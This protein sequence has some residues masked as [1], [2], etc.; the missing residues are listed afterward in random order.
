MLNI[1][2]GMVRVKFAAILIGPAG[3]GLLGIYN[4]II[5]LIATATG[6]GIGN[7]GVRQVAE[8]VGSNDDERIARTVITLRRTA[9]LTGAL[10]M[11]VMII[12]CVP[13]SRVTFG[14][15]NYAIS[16]ALLGVTLLFSA[17]T[18][19][20]ACLLRG[21]RRIADIARITVISAFGGTLIS[22]PCFYL[23]GIR[24]IV[25]SQIL[26]SIA[27]LAT[28]WWYAR[29]FQTVPLMVSWPESR[30]EARSLLSLGISFMGAALATS[31]TAYA[32]QALLVRHFSLADAGIYQA[33]YNLS[34]VLVG[35]VLGAMGADYYPR[36][37]AIAG[38]HS[39][40]HRMV[41]E[42]SQV[43][44]LLALPA[45]AAMMVFAPLI[46]QFFYSASF[47]A[48][49]PLLRWCILGILGRVFSWPIGFVM[50]A[51]GKGTIYFAT[52]AF[53]CGLHLAAVALFTR[54]WGLD[55]AGIAFMALY[56]FYTGLML[57]VMRRLVGET[58]TR[59]T[60]KLIL[61][62]TTI[63]LLLIINCRLNSNLIGAWSINIC[64]LSMVAYYCLNQ[65]LSKSQ[66]GLHELF[67]RLRG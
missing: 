57:I 47:A 6:M 15:S 13:I 19:G 24:G 45:L 14:T 48:A 1:L 39:G 29:R 44:V 25:I 40:V 53:A 34:G 54:I 28:S 16:V 31:A 51:Q 65:L 30:I 62:S 10:G 11:L 67:A 2:I 49:V 37:T 18:T 33:A 4:Q 64:I 52:E 38:D 61:I 35:F 9:W 3:V 23:W 5:A 20:Q 59:Q 46:I 12:L 36:L 43:S 21:A 32:I 17:I 42:Q 26:S 56:I 8:A 27:V 66:L 7:S 63:M 55:G 22:V 50:L 41:N 58:W 60:L